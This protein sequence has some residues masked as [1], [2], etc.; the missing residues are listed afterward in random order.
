MNRSIGIRGLACCALLGALFAFSPVLVAAQADNRAR[1]CAVI[2][3]EGNNWWV[4][5]QC[6][7]VR[8]LWRLYDENRCRTGCVGWGM[9]GVRPGTR[10]TTLR[11]DGQFHIASCEFPRSV[12]VTSTGAGGVPATFRCQDLGG[13]QS[14]ADRRNSRTAQPLPTIPQTP[15]DQR[16]SQSPPPLS[17]DPTPVRLTNIEPTF[18]PFTSPPEVQNRAEVLRALEWEYPAVLRDAG[19][20]GTVRIYF[21]IDEEGRVGGLRLH[22]SSGHEALDAAA[23]R[24][25][26]VF[27]FTSAMNRDERVPVWIEIPI[28]FTTTSPEPTDTEHPASRGSAAGQ[29]IGRLLGDADRPSPAV[30]PE[31]TRDESPRL[32]FLIVD[33]GN[34]WEVALEWEDRLEFLV[35][36]YRPGPFNDSYRPG[37]AN[38]CVGE[39]W[40]AIAEA[41]R[42]SSM[43][44]F[45]PSR[46]GIGWGCG[47]STREEAERTAIA[48]CD[49]SG[50]GSC[51][52]G[53]SGLVKLR[54]GGQTFMDEYYQDP[55][56]ARFWS[57]RVEKPGHAMLK[58]G[59]HALENGADV[60]IY[61]RPDEAGE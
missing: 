8:I 32:A 2:E 28:T 31:P 57:R 23:L 20:G 53:A 46:R 5:N 55:E 27:Q 56:D 35:G 21:F 38:Y 50:V 47:L 60:R 34:S 3:R 9:N 54:P 16:A 22:E 40:N 59:Y 58:S 30:G 24:V 36:A 43:T 26:E 6:S 13:E 44:G 51:Q 29:V 14:D 39:K 42:P 4:R 25:A 48:Q 1:G 33:E 11:P 15:A 19:V 61:P 52:V 45:A 10:E 18:T 17:E 12:I 41:W 37:R 49:L 7:D